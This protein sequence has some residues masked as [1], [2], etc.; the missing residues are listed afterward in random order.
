METLW[1]D[2]RYGV[3][4]LRKAPGFTAIA[5]VT[6]AIGIGANTV[7]FSLVN[8]LLLRPAHVKEPERLAGCR[9]RGLLFWFRYADYVNLRDSNPI[10][11]NLMAHGWGGESVMLQHGDS[12]RWASAMFVSASYFSTL[13]VAPARGRGFWPQEE[14]M[15]SEPVVVLSHRAWQR[16]GG[17][18]H[19]VGTQVSIN[20]IFC[21]VIGVTPEQFTGTALIGPDLWLPLGTHGVVTRYAL[22]SGVSKATPADFASDDWNY[23]PLLMVGRL[24][25]GLSWSAAEARLPALAS[26]LNER[27]PDR[28]VMSGTLH[29]HRPGRLNAYGGSDQKLVSGGSLFLMGVS[30]IILLIACMNLANMYVIQGAS[31]HREIAIRIAIGGG[32][33]RIIRQFFV[34]SL[35]L[36]L[37]G[38]TFGLVLAFW[39]TKVLNVLLAALWFSVETGLAVKAG[40]D[41]RVVAATLGFCL[42]A[43]LLSGLRPALRLSR[44]DIID[45][46]KKSRGSALRSMSRAHRMMPRG[47]SVACQV[48]LS[49]ALVMSA[50]LLTHSAWKAAHMTPGYSFD[51]KLLIEV[52]PRR[53]GYDGAG[54]RQI[55]ERLMDH[56]GA[57]PGV[58]AVGLSTSKPFGSRSKAIREYGTDSDGEASGRGRWVRSGV[59]PIGGDYLEAIGL[60]LLRGRYFSRVERAT[61]APVVIIDEVQARWLRRDGHALGCLISGLGPTPREVIGIVPSLR[62]SLFETEVSAHVYIPIRRDLESFDNPVYINVRTTGKVPGGEIAL[63]QN[64]REGIRRVDPHVAILSAMTLSDHHRQSRD[65]RRVRL[66]AG[67]AMAFGATALFLAALGIYA[68]KGYMVAA[69]TP[70][71]GVRMALGA[72]SGRILRLVLREGAVLTLVG[73][74]AGMLLACGAARAMRHAL[75]GVDPIDPMSIAM[76]VALLGIA[77]A[78]AGYLPARRAARID[79]MMALRYE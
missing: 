51:D 3:R 28:R 36:A 13:G 66:T 5:L 50:S 20:G 53:A 9:S 21:H 73:L 39:C 59:R 35:L 30:T 47:L 38:G 18:P 46:L 71:I 49:V 63:L 74:S 44:R 31:R 40:I 1:Q 8:A 27:S 62:S 24:R 56:L 41:V 16:Q 22:W 57:L 34:E 48:A 54:N 29:L 65:V 10:F 19:I 78:L 23:P 60:P 4:M 25:P 68:V 55:C 79:P 32:R 15:G 70:E 12:T 14:R 77:S 75:F 37:V 33:M 7:M 42:V 45:D 26:R 76:T 67:L 52:E 2:I 69:R 11:S 43:A 17:D 58:Q 64:I 72:T 6:L 61:D